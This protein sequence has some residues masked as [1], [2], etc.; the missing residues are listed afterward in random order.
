M[1]RK[2]G[3]VACVWLALMA[4]ALHSEIKDF[5]FVHTW[6]FSALCAAPALLIALVEVMHSSKA[7]ELH[8]DANRL[9]DEAN[10]LQDEANEAQEEAARYYERA[11]KYR[12]EANS[13][14]AR[15][16]EALARIAEHTKRPPTKSEMN[17]E[18]L[19][20]YLRKIAQVTNADGSSWPKPAEIVEIKDGIV[21]LFT[22]ASSSSPEALGIRAH[23]DKVEAIEGAGGLL[24]LKIVERYGMPENLGQIS[25]W[26]ERENARAVPQFQSGPNVFRTEFSKAGTAERHYLNVFE[27]ADGQNSY[28][29]VSST[30]KDYYGDNIEISRLFLLTQLELETK[31]FTLSGSGTGGSK[32]SSVHQD[33]NLG[34][35]EP[36]RY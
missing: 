33:E 14:R 28:M 29:L 22:P 34:S 35:T 17:A 8:A 11:N 25:R 7:N 27:S 30:G 32:V 5:L 3:I 15:A 24:M 13:E 36:S 4:T 20:K 19:K 26:E 18:T 12:E 16:N 6:I 23:C 31:G 1:T 10:R 9:Q 2:L 21:T